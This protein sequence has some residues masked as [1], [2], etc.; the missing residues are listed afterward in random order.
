MFPFFEV[1]GRVIGTY[2]VCSVVGLLLCGLVAT[3]L[4]K[5]Y[6]I[7]FED[8][9]LVMLVAGAGL[10]VGGHILYS[11]TN[12][13]GIINV[14]SNIGKYGGIIEFGQALAPY[15]GGMVFYGGFIG[16][17][18]ALMIYTKR[19]KILVRSQILD[20]FA[21][22]VPLFHTFGRIG[23]FLGG[24]CY[25]VESS[26]GFITHTNTIS[27]E[28]NGV[29]RFPVQL[30]EAGF[31]FIIFL[32]LL[33]LFLKKKQEGK[34]MYWYLIMYPVVRFTLEFFR[35][36]EI[37]GFLWFFSTSQWLSIILFVFAIVKLLIT[38]RRPQSAMSE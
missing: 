25:G 8:I 1:F 24:C 9:V 16:A 29:V 17:V 15:V 28:I 13:P 5:R 27:P 11:I 20:I 31:N 14:F 37:R 36:D 35:G 18:I 32:V 33:G 26:W 34:I 22:C 12:I 21:V 10:V 23:C 6:K 38:K 3:L 7:A 19:S 4:G 2:S 30:F